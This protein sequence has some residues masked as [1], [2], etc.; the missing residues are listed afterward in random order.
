MTLSPSCSVPVRHDTVQLA[1]GGGGR[2][3][4]E[5]IEQVFAAA[6]DNPVLASRH[7]SAVVPVEAARLAMT[8]DSYVVDPLFFPGGDIGKLAV[9]GTVNDLCMAGAEPAYL[10]A[11]FVLEEGLPI[12]SLV[13][14]VRSMAEACAECGVA[15]VTGD[16]K[17]VDHGRGHGVYLNTAGVGWV[18]DRVDVGPARIQPGDVVLLSG[19]VGRHGIAVMSVRSGLAL[20]TEL[21][22]DCAPLVP[23]VRALI[24]D[25]L[26]VHCLRDLTRGGLASA[27]A[28]LALDA[29]V[30]VEIDEA[31]VPVHDAVR[32]ASELLGLDPLYIA[33]E[34]RMVVVVAPEDADRALGLLR[35]RPVSSGAVRIGSVSKKRGAQGRVSARGALG[36]LRPLSL[37]SGEQLPRIC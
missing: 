25:G 36:N 32:G 4:R 9:F 24:D 17:V 13:R 1:H 35:A 2:L 5:L 37:Q 33:N 8:T 12:D 19:D 11:G 16:T 21:E 29:G 18:R 26:D 14:I 28:E 30:D 22:S 31:R 15:I 23:P 27:L 6:F 20:G 7:D 3:M 10:T 34:G